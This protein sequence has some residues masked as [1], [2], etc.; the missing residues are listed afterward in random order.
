MRRKLPRWVC[1]QL[2]QWDGIYILLS[3]IVGVWQAWCL[4]YGRNSIFVDMFWSVPF[5]LV[6][7]VHAS[8]L[9]KAGIVDERP[10][11]WRVLVLWAGM[12]I[13][14]VVFSLTV[15]M[16]TQIMSAFYHTVDNLPFVDLR[17][18]IGEGAGAV[19]WAGC[20]LVWPVRTN[21]RVFLRSLPALSAILFVGGLSAFGLA[22]VV[23][24]IFH[25]DMFLVLT[26]TIVTAVSGAI[27]VSLRNKTGQSIEVSSREEFDRL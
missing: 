22:I 14:L 20:L 3:G 26:S 17:I 27:L 9:K 16:E 25:R 5:G 13:S 2:N 24:R 10:D 11:W 19:V 6:S 8:L 21:L 4:N 7:Y 18:L 1:R 15:L 23:R 12:Q